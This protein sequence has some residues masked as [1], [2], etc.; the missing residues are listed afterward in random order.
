MRLI[1]KE[2]VA[3]SEFASADLCEAA[4]AL[5]VDIDMLCVIVLDRRLYGSESF[6]VRG[7]RYSKTQIPDQ[8]SQ[9]RQTGYFS[10]F[11]FL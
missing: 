8:Q 11:V 1:Q 3:H 10:P 7:S 6:R 2:H 9:I 5:C 4:R